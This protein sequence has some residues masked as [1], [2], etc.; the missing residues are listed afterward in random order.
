MKKINYHDFFRVFLG[1]VFIL[2]S[3]YRIFFF[4]KG[5]SEMNQLGLPIYFLYIVISLE[6]LLGLSLLS[7][8]HVKLMSFLA[9][10]FLSIALAIITIGNTTAIM[11]NLGELF[12]FDANPTDIVLHLTYLLI[13]VFLFLDSKN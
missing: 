13:L 12:V 2:A 8:K 10:I 4:E 3:T 5:I 9:I 6:F 1:I 7:N 11:S